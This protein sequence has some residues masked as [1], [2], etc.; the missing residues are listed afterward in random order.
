MF[1]AAMCRLFKNSAAPHDYLGTSCPGAEDAAGAAGI[2]DAAPAE[3]AAVAG[4]LAAGIAPST[5]AD[6]CDL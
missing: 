6:T 1:N 3:D 4:A 5:P 2:D